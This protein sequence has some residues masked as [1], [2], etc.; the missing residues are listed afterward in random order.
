MG[1]ISAMAWGWKASSWIAISSDVVLRRE[2]VD[3]VSSAVLPRHG[4]TKRPA[5]RA[6]Y[7]LTSRQ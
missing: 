7:I 1:N 6:A 3:E 2:A 4:I 5:S